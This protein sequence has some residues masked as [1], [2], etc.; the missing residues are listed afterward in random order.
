[1][2]FRFN[3]RIK[4]CKG[5]SLNVGKKG[6]S[7]SVGVKGAKV[8]VG[9]NGVRKTVGVPGTGISYTDYKKHGGNNRVNNVNRT[10]VNRVHKK[11]NAQTKNILWMILF[12]L[13]STQSILFLVP[14]TYLGYKFYKNYRLKNVSTSE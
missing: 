3:K 13:L 9:K 7:V 10:E 11:M 8:T 1:M 2:G 5:V 4:I 14:V 12:I 6:M